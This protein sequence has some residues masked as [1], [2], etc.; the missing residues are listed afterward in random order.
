MFL[1]LFRRLVDVVERLVR[2]Q[3]LLRQNVRHA[4]RQRRLPVINMTDRSHVHVGFRP[5]EFLLRHLDS[6][7]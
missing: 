3:T 2:R 5:L 6:L 1:T 4:A 7:L